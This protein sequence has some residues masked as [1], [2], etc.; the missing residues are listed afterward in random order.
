[1]N[2]QPCLG[3]GG[4]VEKQGSYPVASNEMLNYGRPK[5]FLRSS[6][7][8]VLYIMSTFGVLVHQKPS[9]TILCYLNGTVT[10]FG[11]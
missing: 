4:G 5:A 3:T 9:S 11:V 8:P 7:A 2:P 1:M 10:P 6:F